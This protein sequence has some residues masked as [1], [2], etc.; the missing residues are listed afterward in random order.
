[1]RFI[2]ERPSTVLHASRPLPAEP[3]LD[4]RHRVT[5]PGTRSALAFLPDFDGLLRVAAAGLLHPASG[6]GVRRVSSSALTRKAFPDGAFYP[7]KLF[8][9]WQRVSTSPPPLPS[10]RCLTDALSHVA[11]AAASQFASTSGFSST[12]ESVAPQYVATLQCPMLPWAFHWLPLL[13]PQMTLTSTPPWS[14]ASRT[15]KPPKRLHSSL[16]LRPT[17]AALSG[18]DITRRRWSTLTRK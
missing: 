17:Y 5:K 1:M 18:G 6:H 11:I 10:R 2:K 16:C 14:V 8:P 3:K 4:L 9:P 12:R 13:A 7:P 15:A